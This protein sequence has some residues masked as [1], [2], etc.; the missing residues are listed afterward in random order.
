MVPEI[1]III[2]T[3]NERET[4]EKLIFNI[5]RLKIERL[6]V[7]I[8]DD[9]SPDNTGEIA[10]KLSQLYPVTVIHRKEKLG[11][12]S[13][14]IE[15]FK[16]A[17]SDILGVM[18][19]DLSHPPELIPQMLKEIK[20]HDLVIGSRLIQGG[21]VEKWPILRKF[22][23]LVG[24][25]CAKPLTKVKDPLSGFFF[26][27]R[28]VIDGI[29]LNC[30]GYKILLEILTKGKYQTC[31]ELPIIFKTRNLGQSKLS[32]REYADYSKLLLHLYFYKLKKNLW[33]KST[34]A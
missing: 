30:R 24:V 18:D 5:F 21:K 6:E 10:E 3:Y 17:Q 23:S 26:L 22:I 16:S 15:G 25:L 33:H 14:V 20:N 4:L 29:N 2:P 12:G 31:K 19:A 34:S 9:N 8:V 7:I 27:R 11:L 32:L 28:K 1:S 13:A